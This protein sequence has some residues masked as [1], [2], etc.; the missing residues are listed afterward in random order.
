MANGLPY[1][2][3]KRLFKAVMF[4]L[5]MQREGMHPDS[6]DKQAGEYYRFARETIANYTEAAP[7]WMKGRGVPP[8]ERE[9]DSGSV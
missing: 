8:E 2:P 1:I 5:S 6:A 7:P 3:D 9:A 4:S